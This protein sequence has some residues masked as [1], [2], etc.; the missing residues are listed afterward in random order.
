[1]Y[2]VPH[3]YQL[4]SEN[5]RIC[6]SLSLLCHVGGWGERVPSSSP[7]LW[8]ES[9]QC[10]HHNLD[11]AAHTHVAATPPA[12]TCYPPIHALPSS[13]PPS[14]LH[15]VCLIDENLNNW[16]S[17]FMRKWKVE[18]IND[19]CVLTITKEREREIKNNNKQSINNI[20]S[21]CRRKAMPS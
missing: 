1:M 15:F 3:Q 18:S 5:Q 21:K 2:R 4:V 13:P 16:K 14:H 19:C 6:L 10:T 20:D 17:Q 12:T 9:A 11:A 8:S 7:L